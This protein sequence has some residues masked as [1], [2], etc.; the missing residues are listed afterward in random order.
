MNQRVREHLASFNAAQR[1]GDW[2]PF[3]AGFAHDAVMSFA[4]MPA[5]PY[6]GRAAIAQAYAQRP[7]TDTM[8]AVSVRTEQ[9]TDVVRFAWD[10]GGTGTMTL[11][12]RDGQLTSLHVAFD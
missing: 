5:G 6:T 3:L 1:S 2:R 12:W 9:D 11:R 10:A 4:G 8:R 7:P